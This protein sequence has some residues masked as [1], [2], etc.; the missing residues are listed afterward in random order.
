MFLI[1]EISS[2]FQQQG[3]DIV[4]TTQNNR[5]N[6]AIISADYQGEIIEIESYDLIDTQN[7]IGGPLPKKL[8]VTVKGLQE[9]NFIFV[10]TRDSE[11][12]KQ[13]GGFYISKN[14]F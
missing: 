5:K 6:F 12:I 2:G 8:F 13:G 3:S 7:S 9:P 4:Y 10:S 14:H 1:S 11:N